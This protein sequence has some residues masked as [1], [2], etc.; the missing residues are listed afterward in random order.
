GAT[1]QLRVP[2]GPV[3]GDGPTVAAPHPA[4]LAGDPFA[5]QRASGVHAVLTQVDSVVGTPAYMAPEQAAGRAIDART[6]Q[7]ALAV[8]LLDA[9]LGQSPSRRRLPPTAPASAIDAALDEAGIASGVRAAIVRA[10]SEDPAARFPAIDELLRAL[11]PPAPR[12]S[13]RAASLAAG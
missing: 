10:V 13:R 4:H 2:Q 12:R 11:A 5:R 8:T 9:L 7:Y 6:D 3:T 1:R